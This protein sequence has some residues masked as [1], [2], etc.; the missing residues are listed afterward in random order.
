MSQK[1][2]PVAMWAEPVAGSLRA[3]ALALLN[4]MLIPGREGAGCSPRRVL[5]ARKGTD[6]LPNL[7][8]RE[9]GCDLGCKAVLMSKVLLGSHRNPLCP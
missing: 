3:N 1:T 7:L 2:H 4:R 9:P 6:S 8:C 5:A